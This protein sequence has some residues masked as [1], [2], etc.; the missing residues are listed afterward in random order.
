[1][2]FNG[3]DYTFDISTDNNTWTNYLTVTSSM[4]VF[5]SSYYNGLGF[6]GY[7]T[8]YYWKG[9]IDLNESY[10]N[11]NG[12][13]WWSGINT[14]SY[15]KNDNDHKFYDI[16]DKPYIDAIYESTGL[17]DFYG[18]DTENERIFLTRETDRYLVES[19][20]ATNTDPTWYN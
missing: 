9:S 11:I 3:T 5:A 20:K 17:A 6:Y 4:P 19:K 12:E 14:Y 7:N 1:M 10:L 2:A 18:I 8:A 15:Y 13:R 16:A